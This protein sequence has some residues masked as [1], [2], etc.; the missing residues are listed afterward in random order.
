MKRSRLQIFLVAALLALLGVLAALQYIWLGQISVAEKDRLVRRLQNDT[1]RFGEDFNREIQN[2][3]INFQTD[4]SLWV[5]R[6]WALFNE[7]YDFWRGRTA[8]PNLIKDFYYLENKPEG[9]VLRYDSEKREFIEAASNKEL[10]SIKA[11]AIDE[12][13]FQPVDEARFALVMTVYETPK[14]FERILIRRERKPESSAD[15]LPTKT[16]IELPEKKGF[17]VI[18]L[19]EAV[20][21]SQILADLAKKHFPEGDFN[22]SVKNTN[23]QTIFE[24]R[25]VNGAD[26]TVKL[27][28]LSP[29]NL[30]FFDN[31]NIFPRTP[32]T[33]ER[34]GI[35]VNQSVK[36]HTFSTIETETVSSDKLP[37]RQTVGTFQLKLKSGES[38]ATVIQTRLPGEG[39]WILSVQHVAGSLDKFI[40][41]TR[42]RN[43]GISFGILSLLAVSIVLI[44]VSA[45]RARVFAQRQVDF[46]SSVSHEFRTPLAVIYSAGENLADGVAR[47]E[48]QV[49]RYGNLI[50]SEGRKLSRMVEQILEFAGANAGKTKYDFRTQ[51]V[52]AI[53]EDA[54][55][56]SHS[57]IGEKDFDVEC[58]I[59]ENLPDIKADAGALSRALQNLIGNSL[60]YSNGSKWLKI[61]ASNGGGK[62]K[63]TVEDKGIGIA[64]ADLKHVFEPFYRAK[65][66]VDEQIHGNGLGL[67]LVKETVEAHGGK[68]SAESQIGKGS[69]FI[70]HLPFIKEH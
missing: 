49:S 59:A 61:K 60:K 7:R 38:P 31:Q 44:F 6:N 25:E 39:N 35:I 70:L 15:V 56:E 33:S 11:A 68:I 51:S 66:V 12:K 54:L 30:V 55:R 41:N 58:E 13:T 9:G 29:D 21:K 64:P 17:L 65:Q 67:S 34:N 20:V 62:V 24:T 8:Y 48:R 57:L 40:A 26:Q 19:D 16:K 47:E 37:E 46:V 63:I 45:D 3:Y 32:P 18:K 22:L 43:L 5:E 2:A 36:T 69:R 50:K 23:G 42:N 52:K 14:T 28:G 10:Q 27:F 4:E 53:V 1:E